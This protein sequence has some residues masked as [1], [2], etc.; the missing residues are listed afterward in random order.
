MREMNNARIASQADPMPDDMMEEFRGKGLAIYV[1]PPRS[2]FILGDD[3]SANAMISSLRGAAAAHRVEFMPIAP[4]VA[5]GYCNTR[6]V[7]VDYV[8]AKD[9][10]RMN[11]AMARQSYL[12][13]GRSEAQI[14]SLSRV[15]HDPPDI[16]EG[17]FTAGMPSPNCDAMRSCPIMRP[18]LLAIICRRT[19][20][21]NAGAKLP[22]IPTD[23]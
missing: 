11:E 18:Q 17:F 10:R 2:S 9:V 3:I 21:R 7:L 19:N 13:A 4:N 14:V 20:D 15:P 6:G 12:I 22:S 1:A 16:L 23:Q 8:D 5:V